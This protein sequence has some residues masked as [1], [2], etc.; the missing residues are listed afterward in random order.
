MPIRNGLLST[1]R[2][3]GRSALFT[4]LIFVLTLALTLGA[5][6]WGWSAAALDSF[7]RAYTTVALLEYMG[8]DY[9]APDAA[10]EYARQALAALDQGALAAVE[11]VELWEQTD[12]TLAYLDG[13]CR[14]SGTIPYRDRA[15]VL[16][17]TQFIGDGLGG[18]TGMI[19]QSLY[20]YE[21]KDRVIA[22]FLPGDTGFP[23]ENGRQY[24]L[25]GTFVDSG[26]ANRNFAVAEF[27]EGCETPPYLEVSGPEDPAL[28]QGIFAQYARRYQVANNTV[29]L[30]A[31]DGIEALEAFQQGALYLEAGRFPAPGEAGVCVLDGQAARAMEL[32]VGDRLELELLRSQPADRYEL[33][34]TEEGR[35]LEIV[36]V[37]NP[38]TD[39]E[40]S[41]WVSSAEGGFGGELF[42]FCL[43]R[44]VLDNRRAA[45]AALEMEAL[46]PDQVHL[47]LFD[48]GYAAAAQPIETMR[49]TAMA[50]TLASAAGAAATLLLFAFLFVGRQRETVAIL[51]SLGTPAGKIR[52]WLLSGA[53][54]IAAAAA[55]AGGAVGQGLLGT[56]IERSMEASQRLYTVDPRYSD[57]AIG[58][59][60]E[61]P[62]YGG[63][64]AW[65]G[66]AAGGAV[67]LAALA[68]CL[69][70]LRR[71]CRES[72]PR[73]GRQSVRVPRGGTSTAGRGAVRFALLSARRGG[74]RSG[75]VPAAALA[76]TLLLGV[77]AAAAQGRSDQLDRLYDDTALEGYVSSTSGRQATG[78][79]VPAQAVRTLWDSG[80]LADQTVSVGW[81]YWQEKDMPVFAETEFGWDSRDAWIGQQPEI[82]ALNGLDAAP[83]F[84]YTGRPEVTWLEGWDESVLSRGDYR[85][86]QSVVS[87]MVGDVDIDE[88]EPETYP[89]L[90]GSRFLEK[91]GLALG[92]RLEIAVRYPMIYYSHGARFE[93]RMELM[94]TLQLVG[95]FPSAGSRDNLY[96][97]LAFFCDPAWVAGDSGPDEESIN[98][99]KTAGFTDREGM[100]ISVFATTTL[101]TCRFTL[102]SARDLPAMRDYLT[103]Q[104]FSQP[105][106]LTRNRITVILRDQTFVETVGGLGRYISFSRILFPVLFLVV[107]VLGFVISWLMVNGRR[108]EFAVM[109]GLGASRGRVFASFFLEQ[110]ALCLAGCLAGALVLTAMVREW[111]VWPAA[112]AFLLCYLVG[113]TLSVLLVGRTKLMAL[114]SERE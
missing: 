61:R 44:A 71:A 68:L 6:M 32:G 107:G 95:S 46:L 94:V 98:A 47:T 67:F 63:T 108:M 40:G 96:V 85:P 55:A 26:S 64:P 11:G 62:A 15:V 101:S 37:T 22:I 102:R 92:D 10:D 27:D 73:R 19:G 76:L 49:T 65:C 16:T 12:Q 5:G 52:R 35:S 74:W 70:F 87:A 86:V 72:A 36:G 57:A 33:T 21:G 4:L 69:V 1:L 83:E 18:Y 60:R 114:L 112:G 105:G 78:L 80:L 111:A 13:Y 43:G 51:T 106:R 24:L 28:T 90:A 97:P 88:E 104:N 38:L 109:R 42:G 53:A 56:V 99:V 29:R 54:V 8:Q 100:N 103:A 31:S 17:S 59:V 2:A 34:E 23:A 48:Q 82:V 41:V 93:Q 81:N 91:N 50:V 9:P 75:V 66:P 79:T 3:R 7:D 30:T 39:Y 58:M 84:F 113:C 110:G 77:L 20:S 14:R 45:Q 25:H 89:V